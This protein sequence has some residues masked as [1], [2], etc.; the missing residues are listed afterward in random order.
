M[1]R[2]AE[3]KERDM[4]MRDYKKQ[5]S[6]DFLKKGFYPILPLLHLLLRLRRSTVIPQ[7]ALVPGKRRVIPHIDQHTTHNLVS[8]AMI[9]LLVGMHAR[10][11]ESGPCSPHP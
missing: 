5:V 8:K 7:S 4:F 6:L 10:T 11:S 9:F 1:S 2:Q 3:T